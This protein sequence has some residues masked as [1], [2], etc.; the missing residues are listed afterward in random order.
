MAVRAYILMEVETGKVKRVI[1]E[2]SK[3]DRVKSTDVIMGPYDVI[4]LVE[5]PD[6]DQLSKTCLMEIQEIREVRHT[7]TCPI[8][9]I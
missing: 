6:Y 2:L 1:E 3:L 9:E 4:A 7:M 5:C 8:V